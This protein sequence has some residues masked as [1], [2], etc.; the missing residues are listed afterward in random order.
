MIK[1]N[2]KEFVSNKSTTLQKRN[3]NL[4]IKTSLENAF[5]SRW[6]EIKIEGKNINSRSNH[7]AI[8]FQK[9]LFIHGGYDVDKGVMSDFYSMDLSDHSQEFIWKTLDNLCDGKE[10]K[11][12]GHTGVCYK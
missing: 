11:L 3:S 2:S 9:L 4:V 10:I 12:K 6:A 1:N 7:V 8:V 5:D